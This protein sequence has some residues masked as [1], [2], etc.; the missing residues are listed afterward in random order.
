METFYEF[1][2]QDWREKIVTH[3]TPTGRI[4]RVKVKSL[5]PEEQLKYNPNRFKRTKTDTRMTKSDFDDFKKDVIKEP[6]IFDVYIGLS[7]VKKFDDIEEGKLILAT[8]DPLYV[9]NYFDDD[10]DIIKLRNVPVMA[11]K[12]YLDGDIESIDFL[13]DF[14]FLEV[15]TEDEEKLYELIKFSDNKIFLLDIIPYL[16]MIEVIEDKADNKEDDLDE[17][18]DGNIIDV[19]GAK[20]NLHES[21]LN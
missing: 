11:V 2:G 15:D 14:E 10:L 20:L 21:K 18:K 4:T 19:L 1:F 13:D 6:R 16:D 17:L 8:T 7:D 5:S 12:K 9:M 3:R